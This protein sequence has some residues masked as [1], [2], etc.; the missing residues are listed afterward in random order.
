[1]VL[2]TGVKA[3]MAVSI[4]LLAAAG[5]LAEAFTVFKL[6]NGGRLELFP[7][8]RWALSSEDVGELKIVLMPDSPRVNARAIY[9]VAT[10][11]AD[12]FPTDQKLNEQM[13]RVSERILS[14]GDFVE[15]KPVV[16]PFYPPKGFGY[17]AVMTDRKLVGLPPKSGDYK[18]FMLGMIRLAPSVYLK[19]QIMA[20]H[21][22]GEPYQQL[23][24]MAEGA[25]YTPP[26]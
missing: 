11:G 10:E 22:E 12:D 19:V 16:K 9:S 14:S 23:L 3:W 4:F 1:M 6:P 26:R 15:R 25:V 21:E 18:F 17:Y 5:G 24:G 13:V 8:G 2:I 7:V 20:D